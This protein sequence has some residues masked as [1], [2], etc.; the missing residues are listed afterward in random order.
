MPQYFSTTFS[1][2]KIKFFVT[3]LQSTNIEGSDFEVERHLFHNTV[4]CKSVTKSKI[5]IFFPLWP[6]EEVQKTKASTK[7]CPIYL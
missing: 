2:V 3:H 5:D 4:C 1:E 6:C 7:Q